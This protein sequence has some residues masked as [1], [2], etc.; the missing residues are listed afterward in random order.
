MNRLVFVHRLQFQQRMLRVRSKAFKWTRHPA[1]LGLLD[2]KL[3]AVLIYVICKLIT[4][5]FKLDSI[6]DFAVAHKELNASLWKYY[7]GLRMKWLS[8]IHCHF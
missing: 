6:W 8:V 4:F 7:I 2:L 3:K 1:F 5:R